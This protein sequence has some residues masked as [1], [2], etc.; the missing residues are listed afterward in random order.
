MDITTTSHG[1]ARYGMPPSRK[2]RYRLI[3]DATGEPVAI[4]DEN[5]KQGIVPKN[6]ARAQKVSTPRVASPTSR[7]RGSGADERRT[8]ARR[9][10][11]S[12]RGRPARPAPVEGVPR[13]HP[14]HAGRHRVV[15]RR[16]D[17]GYPR[18]PPEGRDRSPSPDHPGPRRR[19]RP[20]ARLKAALEPLSP[21]PAPARPLPDVTVVETHGPL[22]RITEVT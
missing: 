11:R 3:V 5:G 19:S 15:Y 13:L 1:D 9:G 20:D 7:S 4:F 17:A 16:W 18:R 6:R 22:P 8:S 14:P 2:K 21:T 10:E 12:R